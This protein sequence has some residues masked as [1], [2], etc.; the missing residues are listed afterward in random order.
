MSNA[1]LSTS[2]KYA[3]ILTLGHNSSHSNHIPGWKD[4]VAPAREHRYS[5]TIYGVIVGGHVLVSF[6]IV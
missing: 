2:V 1:T 3:N 5:G 6:L 4:Y